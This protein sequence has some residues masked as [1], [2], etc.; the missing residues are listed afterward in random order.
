LPV[1]VL[2]GTFRSGRFAVLPRKILVVLQFTVSVT[3]IIGTIIVYGQ[4]E[5]AKNRPIGYNRNGIIT[6]PLVTSSIHEH[7]NVVKEE[8]LRTGAIT[9]MA[10]SGSPTTGIWNSSSGFDWKG[11]DPNLSIDFGNVNASYDFGKTIGWKIKAGRDFSREFVTDSAAFILNEAAVRF[12]GLKNPVGET[13]TWFGSPF[14][15]IGVVS[16]MIMESPY[17]EVRPVIFSLTNDAGNVAILRINPLISAK[18][19]LVKIEPVFKKFDPE[20]PF[21]YKFADEEY[22][23][24]FGNEERIGKLA[25]FFAGLAIV[26]CCLGLFGLTGFVAEQRKKEIGVR[27]ILGASVFSVWNLLSRDFVKLALISF[28]VAMPLSYYFMYDW[29]QGYQYHTTISWWVF[30]ASGSGLMLIT[31]LTV[32]FQ[33]IKAAISNPVNSLRTE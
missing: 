14:T 24:K 32:S 17:D 33:A 1:K 3:L 25:G 31:L 23:A 28:L 30:V 15:V 4:I 10:E 9:S 26:I 27:K 12:M 20:Q 29:L 8:L 21:E 6:V 18:D 16:D 5:F 7:I 19:A 22:G 11:K 13:V 2:K